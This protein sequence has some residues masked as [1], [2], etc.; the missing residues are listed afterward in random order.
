MN[1][2]FLVIPALLIAIGGGTVFAQSNLFATAQNNPVISASEAKNIALKQLDG[3]I[4]DFEFDGD[5]RTP[6]YEIDIIKGNEKIEVKIDAITGDM[7][8]TERKTVRS[9]QTEKTANSSSPTQQN[10]E[11]RTENSTTVQTASPAQAEAETKKNAVSQ[12]ISQ[13]QAIQIAQLKAPGKVTNFEMDEDD[14]RLVYEIEIRN[15]KMEYDFEI[16][17][18]TGVII[19]YEEDLND[20]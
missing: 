13:Q 6:H 19:K 8:V 4:T 18:N 17:A 10:D 7:R 5:G 11:Q 2:K 3:N 9:A 16:D 15:G 20:D 1:K 14:N 12:T